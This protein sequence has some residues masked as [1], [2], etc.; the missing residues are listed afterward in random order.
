MRETK[1]QLADREPTRGATGVAARVLVID[2]EPII[3]DVLQ[4]IL[5][6]EGYAIDSVPDAES[7][8]TA[9]DSGEHDLVILDLMLPGIG[10]FETLKEIKRRDPDSVVVMI[11][12]YGSGGPALRGMR[13]GAAGSPP[14]PSRN[15]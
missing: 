4:D 10:G 6:R 8:L 1:A 15:A 5:S 11:T 13:G 2:D 7:G 14:Q 9:L 3:R 12:A